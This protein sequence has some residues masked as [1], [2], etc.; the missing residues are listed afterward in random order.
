LRADGTLEFLGRIDDQINLR[1]HR[2]EPG[3]IAAVLRR[4]P[5][6]G[7]AAVVVRDDPPGGPRLVAYLTPALADKPPAAPEIRAHLRERLPD[8][9]VPSAF[10]VLDSLPRSVQGKLD[11]RALP[12]PPAERPGGSA[13][14]V[15]PR[16]EH[17]ALVAS[18][19]EE[20]LGVRPIGL[21][22]NF[23]DLGGHSMLAVRVM[24][25]IERRTGRRLPL[26]SLF[27]QATVQPA[28]DFSRLQIVLVITNFRAINTVPLVPT[29]TP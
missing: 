27:Q 15:A 10:V 16:D 12:P 19:W 14:Y 23:F 7:Q 21:V 26:A 8:H 28:V 5:G 9:M 22:D 18:V 24:A 3:E 4:Y 17:E 29:T 1:G 11:R 25:E 2:V 20:L 13:G 6:V